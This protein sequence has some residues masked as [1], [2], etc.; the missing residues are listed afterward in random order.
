MDLNYHHLRYFQIVA[1]E[2]H[3]TRAAELLNVSQSAL[4]SQIRQL[5]DRLGQTLFDRR[6]RA[7]HLTEAGLIALDH[8]DSIFATG[9]ELVSILKEKSQTRRP[10][11]IG[12]IATL[13]RNFQLGFLKPVL[14]RDDVEVILRSGSRTELFEALTML[15]LD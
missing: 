10:L 1:H 4:S 5:E 6:G 12:A 9:K 8:A 3:L 13:S 11:R 7:L 14:G 2:G 15:Q